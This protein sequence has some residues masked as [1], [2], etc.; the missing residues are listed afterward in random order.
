[1]ESTLRAL[2]D[3]PMTEDE[4]ISLIK[5]IENIQDAQAREELLIAAINARAESK[6]APK[7][8]CN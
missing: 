2:A 4:H 3:S 8:N 5:A 1:M 6:P 7:K